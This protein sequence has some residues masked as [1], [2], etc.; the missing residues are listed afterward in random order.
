MTRSS[1][2]S[3]VIH[4]AATS[5]KTLLVHQ[6]Y[7]V[8]PVSKTS[9]ANPVFAS[10]RG[11]L[12]LYLKFIIIPLFFLDDITHKKVIKRGINICN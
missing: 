10:E 7:V 8:V 11:S 6:Y 4:Y 2:G 1:T 3:S 5:A 9:N 12:L